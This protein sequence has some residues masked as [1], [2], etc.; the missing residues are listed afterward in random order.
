MLF[1]LLAI[2]AIAA[3]LT[4]VALL[5]AP[6]DLTIGRA[7]AH[8]LA[9]I[10]AT[11]AAVLTAAAFW[12]LYLIRAAGHDCALLQ[13]TV[14]ALRRREDYDATEFALTSRIS[15]L[16]E[17]F[18]HTRN[19]EAVLNEAARSLK[20]TLQ[21]DAIV[22]QLYD[23]ENGRF[24]L[25]IEEGGGPSDLGDAIR[26]A[27]IERGKAVLV[28]QLAAAPAHAPLAEAGYTALM[29]APLGRGRR[30]TDRAIGLIAALLK[31][32]RDL[33]GRELSLLTHFARHA[34]LIIENAQLYK[35]AEHLAEHDG[36]TNLFNQRHFVATLNAEL[37]KAAKLHAPV[38]LIMA[39]LD[40]FKAY[41][42][43]HGHLRGDAVL[44]QIARILTENTRQRDIAARYGGEEFVVILP[45]T[46]HPGA[47]RVAEAIRTAVE[48][49][50]FEGGERSG[51]ITITLGVAVFPNDAA[52]AETLIQKADDALYRG[53][54]E[55][56]NRVCW[57]SPLPS[58][59]TESPSQET[60]P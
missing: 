20:A 22:L 21:V 2:A 35:R 27:V 18:T 58:P 44:R 36:L 23:D 33:T 19:L 3:L 15:G 41:N 57:A 8:G 24:T 37:A 26:H 34:G 40:N 59:D 6:P 38:A 45:A 1:V 52:D 50:D 5:A 10:A 46:G 39:D 43:T 25:T 4:T 49:F 60:S 14:E 16:I 31:A 13:R 9:F 30:A 56:K 32:P 54:R 12:Q 55:G 29:A 48:R 51:R 11:L 42:D 47:H 28:N 53:K 7:R 17:V